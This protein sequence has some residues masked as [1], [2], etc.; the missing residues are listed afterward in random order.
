MGNKQYDLMIK[1]NGKDVVLVDMHDPSGAVCAALI[2]TGIAAIGTTLFKIVKFVST[3]I[4]KEN[5]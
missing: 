1:H 4:K 3:K 2:G 5:D